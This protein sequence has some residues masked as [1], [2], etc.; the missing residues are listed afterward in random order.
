MI[1][2]LVFEL[3]AYIQFI[4]R[5]DNNRLWRCFTHFCWKKKKNS[6]TIT[7]QLIVEQKSGA[8]NGN[9]VQNHL[10]IALLKYF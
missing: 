1:I 8:P 4:K 2:E 5:Q 7:F 9:I 10:N 6:I 3:Q